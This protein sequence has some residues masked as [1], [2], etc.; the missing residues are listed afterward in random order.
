MNNWLKPALIVGPRGKVIGTD[1]DGAILA[2][3]R[4]D[5]EAEHLGNVESVIRMLQYVRKKRS[6]IWFMPALYSRT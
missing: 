6:M 2:L 3:A 4:E 5:A 1:S